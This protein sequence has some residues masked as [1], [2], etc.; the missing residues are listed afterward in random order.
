MEAMKVF[1]AGATGV[2]GRRVVRLLTAE[3]HQVVGLSRSPANSE[4]LAQNGARPASGDLFDLEHMALLAAGCEAVLHLATAIPNKTRGSVADWAANDRIR[5]DGTRV[6]VQAALRNH[7]RLYVQQSVTFIYG[8][9]GADWVDENTPVPAQPGGI[10]QSAVDMEQI[11]RRAA[12][13]QGLPAAILR[14]G[15]FYCYDSAQTRSI[16]DSARRGAFPVIGNGEAYWSQIQV[17]DA[18]RAVVSAVDNSAQAA[19]AT[20]NVC[21]NE[22]A[23]YHEVATF[24]AQAL[25]ARPP[26]RMPAVLA[27]L[28]VGSLTVGTLTTS[29][30]VRNRLID[31]Q[32]GW[33]P[34]YPTYR[35]GYRAEIQ[36]W[37]G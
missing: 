15:M 9:H 29:L 13:E 28:L 6:L 11:V 32:L 5:R 10:L 14:L 21:D 23:P 22:P 2:L 19:G 27:R 8:D 12:Q 3:G 1:I 36:K 18:A 20:Y 34:Q 31:E 25:G 24:L 26:K 4:W 7:A 33:R 37:D 35:E 17:D 16:L 30:R